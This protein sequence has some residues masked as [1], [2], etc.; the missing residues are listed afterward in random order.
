MGVSR[1]TASVELRP[2]NDVSTSCSSCFSL[3][4]QL[5]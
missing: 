2:E 4:S 5:I 1:S 3:V